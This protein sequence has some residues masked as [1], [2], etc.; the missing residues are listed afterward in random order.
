MCEVSGVYLKA[1]FRFGDNCMNQMTVSEVR[2]RMLVGML[3]L[4]AH[5]LLR[6]HSDFSAYQGQPKN[7]F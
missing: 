1:P 3:I 5:R 4:E 6:V 2:G 7:R